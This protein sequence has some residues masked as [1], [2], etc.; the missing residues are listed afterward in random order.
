MQ[1]LTGRPMRIA[2]IVSQFPSLTETFI[3]REVQQMVRQGQD[4]TICVLRPQ[5]A[6]GPQGLLIPEARL[7][8]VRPDVTML[9]VSHLWALGTCATPYFST[10]LD[11]LATM[12]RKPSRALH[13]F[14]VWLSAIWLAYG[15]RTGQIKYIHSHFLHNEAISAMWLAKVLKV[16]YGVTSHVA[17]IRQDRRLIQQVVNSADVLVGD[18]EQTLS[19]YHDLTN[20]QAVLV[21][22]GVD[23]QQLQVT[24]RISICGDRE[25]LILAVGTFH[26]A[27][28]FHVLIQACALL[29]ER[30][31]HFRCRI[32][33]EG[34]ERQNLERLVRENK[35]SSIVDLPGV[36]TF[37]ALREQYLQAT[38]LVMPSIPSHVGSDG[39]PTVLI[40]AMAQGIPVIGTRHAGLPELVR[41][42]QTGLLAEPDDAQ[43]LAD[44]IYTYLAEPELRTQMASNGRFLVEHE[45]DLRSN[46]VHLADLMIQ[47]VRNYGDARQ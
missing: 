16:P 39:L 32:I 10:L 28:G 24:D 4:V 27:K 17:S 46:G 6:K 36:L 8:R 42:R 41:H 21:R 34:I 40:E 26:H 23:L 25:P 20:R 43:M 37:E 19:V 14:Y 22:N 18:T 44:C 5:A 12:L 31:E 29:R 45:F 47:A 11:A 13:L 30:M 3:A 7:L 33:G 38:M 15:L 2:Y 9:F 35:L 1:L